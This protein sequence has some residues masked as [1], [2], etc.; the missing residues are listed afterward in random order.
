MIDV[1]RFNS[2]AAKP[3]CFFD[4]ASNIL[5]VVRVGRPLTALMTQTD[6]GRGGVGDRKRVGRSARYEVS[7]TLR[8]GSTKKAVETTKTSRAGPDSSIEGG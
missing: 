1:Q 5:R 6:R 3:P 7:E 8:G 4:A 2:D